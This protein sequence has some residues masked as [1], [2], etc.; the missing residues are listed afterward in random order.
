MLSQVSDSG[1]Q[2]QATSV[3]FLIDVIIVIYFLHQLFYG[4]FYCYS[5]GNF[6][7]GAVIFPLCFV[8]SRQLFKVLLDVDI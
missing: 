8:Y 4:N 3:L 7:F 6:I 2:C 5:I 1:V